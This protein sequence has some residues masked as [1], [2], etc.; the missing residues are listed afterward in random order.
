MQKFQEGKDKKIWNKFLSFPTCPESK[1]KK[2]FLKIK[3]ELGG[4]RL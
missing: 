3:E 1:L 4:L 2:S